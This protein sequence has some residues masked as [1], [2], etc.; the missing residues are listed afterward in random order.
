MEKYIVTSI[1]KKKKYPNPSYFIKVLV[2]STY[3]KSFLY[4]SDCFFSIWSC[5]I[6]VFPY[7]LQHKTYLAFGCCCCCCDVLLPGVPGIVTRVASPLSQSACVFRQKY[8]TD[9]YL[10]HHKVVLPHPVKQSAFQFHNTYLGLANQ[11]NYYINACIN[12][13]WQHD[14]WMKPKNFVVPYPYRQTSMRA[15]IPDTPGIFHVFLP[16]SVLP[17]FSKVFGK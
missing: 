14:F 15:T 5:V 4:Y 2:Y 16:F 7:L 12:R 3:V 17:S 8:Q 13:L 9:K 11:C 1:F 6:R 10:L